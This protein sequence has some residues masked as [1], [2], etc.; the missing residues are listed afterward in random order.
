[1]HIKEKC[2]PT[3]IAPD[4]FAG[5]HATQNCRL[6]SWFTIVMIDPPQAGYINRWAATNADDRILRKPYVN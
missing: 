6:K 4:F 1:M 3:P 5:K 2:C